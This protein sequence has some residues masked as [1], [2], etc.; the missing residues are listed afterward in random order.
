MPER[1]EPLGLQVNET[2]A[3]F[4]FRPLVAERYGRLPD[5]GGP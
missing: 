4:V 2:R 3:R 1:Y 5:A